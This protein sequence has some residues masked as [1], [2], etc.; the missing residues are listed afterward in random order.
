MEI[1]D[2][3]GLVEMALDMYGNWIG[4]SEIG[5]FGQKIVCF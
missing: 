2:E 4:W 3:G 1:R 5:K